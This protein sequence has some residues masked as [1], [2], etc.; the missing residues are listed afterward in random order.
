MFILETKCL[1]P[2]PYTPL[3]TTA[4]TFALIISLKFRVQDYQVQGFCVGMAFDLMFSS[5]CHGETLR[6]PL[7]SPDR[8][9]AVP[10]PSPLTAPLCWFWFSSL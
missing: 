4:Q 1:L 5:L 6:R 7:R 8:K 3:E 9:V 2:F 10:G